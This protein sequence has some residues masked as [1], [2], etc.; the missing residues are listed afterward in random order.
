[1]ERPGESCRAGRNVDSLNRERNGA[2]NHVVN[3]AREQRA[4]NCNSSL[5]ECVGNSDVVTLCQTDVASARERQRELGY[6]IAVATV[7]RL[8][9]TRRLHGRRR[10]LKL[11]HS[12]PT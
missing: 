11:N 4:V 6:Y 5:V 1:M 3:S 7:W 8:P 9:N 2:C 12:F 10:I